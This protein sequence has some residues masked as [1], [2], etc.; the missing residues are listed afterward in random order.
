MDLNEAAD[1]AIAGS[2]FRVKDPS[3]VGIFKV[4]SLKFVLISP[5]DANHSIPN[6]TSTPVISNTNKSYWI[7][8]PCICNFTLLHTP[9]HLIFRPSP[10][11][12]L[13]GLV[14]VT[15]ICCCFNTS[16]EMKL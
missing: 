9:S 13:Y 16:T 14:V 1:L 7:C 10:T 4:N 3:V 2:P 15:G 12:T 5:R 8:I 11:S 6:T